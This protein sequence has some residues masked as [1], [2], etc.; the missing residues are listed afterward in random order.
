MSL[1]ARTEP[2]S[3]NYSDHQHGYTRRRHDLT[4][5]FHAEIRGGSSCFRH[6]LPSTAGRAARLAV[7]ENKPATYFKSG[8]DE[9]KGFPAT[10]TSGKL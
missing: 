7:S 4:S 8:D 9:I 6:L 1:I 5:F 3:R 10:V 2:T